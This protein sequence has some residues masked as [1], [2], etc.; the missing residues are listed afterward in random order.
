MLQ[1]NTVSKS[2]LFTEEKKK[3][4]NTDE[5]DITKGAPEN[6]SLSPSKP[7]KQKLKLGKNK[8]FKMDGKVTQKDAPTNVSNTST[9]SLPGPK[10]LK[11]NFKP[12]KNKK[13][14][15]EKPNPTNMN[16]NKSS[17]T[18]FPKKDKKG[19]DRQKGILKK[20]K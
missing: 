9:P 18:I 13:F 20:Q 5:Q 11:P 2:C 17:K 8:K 7:Q 19:K 1:N 6:S 4:E 14:K 10:L 3:K 12:G 15:T 16:E